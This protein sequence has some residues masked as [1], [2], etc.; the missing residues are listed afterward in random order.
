MS[1]RF[2][3]AMA[4]KKLIFDDDLSNYEVDSLLGS[5]SERGGDP[6]VILAGT[7]EQVG[8]SSHRFSEVIEPIVGYDFDDEPVVATIKPISTSHPSGGILK[9]NTSSY[10]KEF[11]ML[12]LRHMY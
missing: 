11:D 8:S 4:G 3:V 9:E 2:L 10:C 6:E 12:K 5:S 7:N 1:S